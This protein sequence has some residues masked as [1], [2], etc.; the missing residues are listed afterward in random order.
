MLKAFPFSF[1]G[2]LV[3]VLAAWLQIHAYAS[4]A[5]LAQAPHLCQIVPFPALFSALEHSTEHSTKCFLLVI[6]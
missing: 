1:Y 6:Q 5:I 4:V 3:E 2:I